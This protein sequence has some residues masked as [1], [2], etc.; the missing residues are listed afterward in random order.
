[1]VVRLNLEINYSL[2][3]NLAYLP[4]RNADIKSRLSFAFQVLHL[5]NN[6]S[7]EEGKR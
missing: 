3:I 4:L 1:M 5:V 7:E 2:R 6:M